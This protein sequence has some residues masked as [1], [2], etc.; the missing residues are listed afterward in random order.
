VHDLFVRKAA[1]LP[2]QI[3]DRGGPGV[4][5]SALAPRCMPPVTVH[6]EA[7]ALR[8]VRRVQIDN[9]AGS[10]RERVLTYG[11]RQPRTF[12][13]PQK[14]ALQHGRGRNGQLPIEDDGHWAY[15]VSPSAAHLRVTVGNLISRFDALALHSVERFLDARVLATAPRSM[16]V[17]AGVVVR[18]GPTVV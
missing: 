9:S 17:R 5:G 12:Q 7:D 15:A 14:P 13:Q 6:L 10:E 8:R 16:S 1:Q 2:A 3:F 4:V 11:H 18:I